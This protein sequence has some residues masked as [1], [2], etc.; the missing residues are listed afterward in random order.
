MI[1]V[2]DVHGM[3]DRFRK[4][5]KRLKAQFPDETVVQVGDLGLGF[6]KSQ[7]PDFPKQMKFIRGNHD[8]PAF[9]RAHPNYLGDYGTAE[10]DG[11]R[12]FYLSGAWSI[13]RAMRVEG[14]SWWPE[15][16]LTIKELGEAFDL[17]L[18]YK[19]D[20]VITHDGPNQA[21]QWILTRFNIGNYGSY[22][23]ESVKPTR[24]G[25]ALSAMFEAY[26]PKIW[27]FGH[28]HF[29][30]MKNL[31]GTRFICLNEFDVR[32]MD[33]INLDEER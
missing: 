5:L 16:E 22:R 3:L 27:F 8:A 26:Q 28:W 25:Q 31:N 9:C 29:S 18:E 32:R 13:D 10:I 20:V 7:S 2:G 1:L 11:H 15:E 24:T 23:E 17:Y 33:E 14:I 12:V 21:T 4:E 6:P 30:W 19:P